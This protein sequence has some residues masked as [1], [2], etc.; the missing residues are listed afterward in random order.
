MAEYQ[1]GF[2]L[3][4]I[5]NELHNNSFFSDLN[6]QVF[7]KI[8]PDIKLKYFYRNETI[9]KAKQ[10]A[11]TLYILKE[12]EVKLVF[13]NKTTV[14]INPGDCFG[15][16]AAIDIENYLF[17]AIAVS[18][19]VIVYEIDK[20]LVEKVLESNK[21]KQKT[22]YFSLLERCSGE[23]N[24]SPPNHGSSKAP[25]IAQKSNSNTVKSVG[26]LLAL[27]VPALV[28]FA[29][30][31]YQ[32]GFGWNQYIFIIILSSAIMMWAFNLLADF[33]PGIFIILSLLI[34]GVAPSS[35]VL[36]G[37]AS[38]SFFMAMSLFGLGAILTDSGIIYRL[39]L[40]ISKVLPKSEFWY[41]NAILITGI[42]LTPVLPSVT[43]RIRLTG[44]LLADMIDFLNF[45]Y[46][47]RAAT[48]LAASA[49]F[50]VE[51]FSCVFLSGQINNFLVYGILSLQVRQEFTWL[52]WLIASA[53]TGLVAFILYLIITSLLFRESE[54]PKI[55]EE[56]VEAQLRVIGPMSKLEWLSLGGVLVFLVGSL[57]SS[58]HK[59]DLPWI[60]LGVFYVFLALELMGKKKFQ[61]AIDW[62]YLV[63]LGCL[64]G[65]AHT[66]SYI[67]LD[68][69]LGNKLSWMAYFMKN[70]FYLFIL[71]LFFIVLIVRFVFPNKTTIAILATI[72]IPLAES[73]GIHPWLIGLMILNFSDSWLLPYQSS[74]YILLKEM[75]PK[76]FSEK[77]VL[78]TN[79]FV[80]GIRLL[81]VYASLPYWK[82]LGLL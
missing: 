21:H 53:V 22:L 5:A 23:K 44:V 4:Q 72:L 61:T 68:V 9:F 37:F 78:L 81:A 38:G 56:Q 41:S 17:N 65:L 75:N 18:P 54:V 52:Y 69:W 28:F 8:L 2:S 67:G 40:W 49:Y 80:T 26:W 7:S 63:L 14:Q 46:R 36:S 77:L 13:K 57:T 29:S 43:G 64:I 42:L 16:E 82:Y 34:L 24:A 48:H 55:S 33:I 47:G 6:P 66:M 50:G 74:Y 15:E 11:T 70:D 51:L 12:G 20:E 60:G 58:L 45:K 31:K 32:A 35:E 30:Y 76:L 59:I 27:L 71:I 3:E 19:K 62:S 73:N 39:I 25:N 1:Q 79:V 10:P